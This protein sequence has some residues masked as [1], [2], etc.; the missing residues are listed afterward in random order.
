MY[1][2]IP[3]VVD[4][5][6]ALHVSVNPSGMVLVIYLSAKLAL[7]PPPSYPGPKNIDVLPSAFDTPVL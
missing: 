5:A 4:A 2:Y 7:N 1:A 6:L 3:E